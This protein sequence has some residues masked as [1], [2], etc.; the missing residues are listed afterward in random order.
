MLN[1]LY[2]FDRNYNTQAFVSI[3]SVLQIVTE[4]INL[5]L[6]LDETN[7]NLNIPKKIINHKNINLIIEEEINIFKLSPHNNLI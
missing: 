1:F 5:Y 3:Y 6:I 2:A 4:K 7:K